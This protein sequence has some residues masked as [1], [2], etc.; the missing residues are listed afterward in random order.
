AMLGKSVVMLILLFK[1]VYTRWIKLELHPMIVNMKQAKLLAFRSGPILISNLASIGLNHSQST[2][3]GLLFGPTAATIISVTDKLYSL[4]KT[5]VYPIGNALLQPLSSIIHLPAKFDEVTQKY[6]HHMDF[7]ALFCILLCVEINERFIDI[8]LGQHYY[9]GDLVSAALAFSAFLIIRVNIFI[10]ILNARG[11]FRITSWYTIVDLSLRILALVSLFY[12]IKMEKIA[13][14]PIAECIGILIGTRFVLVRQMKMHKALGAI[15]FYSF[16]GLVLAGIIGQQ[17]T[18]YQFY[19]D[20]LSNLITGGLLV[21]CMYKVIK[22]K[23]FFEFISQVK[24]IR[25]LYPRN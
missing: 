23:I 1:S 20:L 8:W 18:G 24:T 5:F 6:I 21:Y 3:I 22:G 25:T 12:V 15:V 14:L 4:V 16:I 10:S 7:L 17:M 2:I 11:L 9:G 13:V 19:F